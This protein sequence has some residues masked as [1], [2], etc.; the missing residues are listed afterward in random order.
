M[1]VKIFSI[2]FL[3]IYICHWIWSQFLINRQYIGHVLLSTLPFSLLACIFSWFTFR[4]IT[5]MLTFIFASL[6]LALFIS[7]GSHSSFSLFLPSHML[8]DHCIGSHLDLFMEFMSTSLC[9]VFEWML[10]VL[11]YT[12]VTSQFTSINILPQVK[13]RSLT[14]IQVHLPSQ[15]LNIFVLCMRWCN[16]FYFNHQYAL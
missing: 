3:P 13:Y 11:Q 15:L 16:N 7:S 14:F 10:W 4:V 6:L 9:V 5:E 1:H 8:L 12:Y 2:H